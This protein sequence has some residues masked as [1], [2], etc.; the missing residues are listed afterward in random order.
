[1]T[2]I[3]E[4]REEALAFYTDMF[5]QTDYMLEFHELVVKKKTHSGG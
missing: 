1:M 4:L 5:N 2:N 3:L